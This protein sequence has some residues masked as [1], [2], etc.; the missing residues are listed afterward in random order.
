LTLLVG[1][2][3][4]HPACVKLSDEVLAWLS[5]WSKIQMI[6]TWSSWCHSLRMNLSLTSTSKI[7]LTILISAHWTTTLPNL[8]QY[9][10]N[11]LH[12][13]ATLH[14]CQ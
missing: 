14:I 9:P 8:S 6:C 5:L 2:Q 7:Y 4:Q 10:F 13:V 12:T 3:E 11:R 1:H